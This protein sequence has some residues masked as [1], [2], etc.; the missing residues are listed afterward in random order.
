MDGE[1]LSDLTRI[2]DG[3][4]TGEEIADRQLF[5]G[6]YFELKPEHPA[7][8][9]VPQALAAYHTPPFPGHLGRIVGKQ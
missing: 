7:F 8:C 9:D 2:P 1:Q 3:I 4:S 5:L 6:R